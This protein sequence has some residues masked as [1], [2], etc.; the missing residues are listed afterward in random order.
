MVCLFSPREFSPSFSSIFMCLVGAFYVLLMRSS[1]WFLLFFA[2]TEDSG[3]FFVF[4]MSPSP[5][6]PSGAVVLIFAGKNAAKLGPF[7]FFFVH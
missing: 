4:S 3:R 5:L 7:L 6:P 1:V 2:N